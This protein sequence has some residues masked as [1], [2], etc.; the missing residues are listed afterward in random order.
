MLRTRIAL[1]ALL[2]SAVAPALA[3][4]ETW[5]N[6]A[7]VDQGCAAKEKVAASPDGHTRDCALQCAK[8]GFG[9]FT[10][11]GKFLKLD[12][13][14]SKRALAALKASSQKDHLRVNVTGALADGAI[15]VESLELVR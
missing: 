9:V 15:H 6:V 2:V 13:E 5:N 4:A 14:G 7:L 11:D 12:A 10:A 3:A 8:N 1:A